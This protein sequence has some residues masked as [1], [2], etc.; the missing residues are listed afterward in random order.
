PI[1]AQDANPALEA[2]KF[3]GERSC[4]SSSCHGGAGTNRDQYI[5]WSKYDFHHARPYATLETA[6]AERI[7]EASKLGDPTHS[8]ACTVCH[9]PFQAVPETELAKRVEI[10]QGVS[11]ESCQPCT[12][13]LPTGH[14]RR[15][16][17]DEDRI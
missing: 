10:N 6:R 14:T 5:A 4:S 1:Q 13:H 9:A 16:Y 15:N 17:T 7:A 2:P 3:L 12:M 11:C 8:A